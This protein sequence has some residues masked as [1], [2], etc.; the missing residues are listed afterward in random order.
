MSVS[1]VLNV[2]FILSL[3]ALSSQSNLDGALV[4]YSNAASLAREQREIE[5]ICLF[6]KGWIHLLQ[7]QLDEALPCFVRWV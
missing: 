7:L 2:Y 4:A 6:E 1:N 3:S 5:H